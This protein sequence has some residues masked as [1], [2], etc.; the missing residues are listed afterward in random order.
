M[1]AEHPRLYPVT[2]LRTRYGGT[3]EGGAWV[4]L[5]AEPWGIPE[6]V[7]G[8]DGGCMEFFA[9]CPYPIGRGADP[10]AAV[11]DLERQAAEWGGG[12]G[13]WPYGAP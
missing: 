2:V 3:Y 10:G 11:A 12:P 1:A 8:D 5:H 6:D 4:A 7:M 13:D 9:S